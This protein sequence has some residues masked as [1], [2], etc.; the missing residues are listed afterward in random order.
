MAHLERRKR[1]PAAARG[2]R[3]EGIVQVRFRIDGSGNVLTADLVQSSGYGALDDEAI[4]LVIRASP[5]PEPPPGMNGTVTVPIRFS[6][7]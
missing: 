6:V 7:K 1:Y 3:E 5:V 4:D 2:R